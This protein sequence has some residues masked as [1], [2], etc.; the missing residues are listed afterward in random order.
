M[1]N[2][3]DFLKESNEK[4]KVIRNDIKYFKKAKKHAKA[5]T[6]YNKMKRIGELD[7]N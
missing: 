6:L 3:N 4:L 2:I 5:A 7:V 1:K